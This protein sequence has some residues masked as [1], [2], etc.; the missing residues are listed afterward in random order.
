MP[1]SPLAARPQQRRRQHTHLTAR[2]G[3]AEAQ[4]TAPPESIH[5]DGPVE[6]KFIANALSL[7]QSTPAQQSAA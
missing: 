7:V 3:V 1:Q 6:D 4:Q 2:A 5:H